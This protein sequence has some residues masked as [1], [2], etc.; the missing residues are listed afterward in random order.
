MVPFRPTHVRHPKFGIQ[1]L[2][3]DVAENWAF[4]T[5]SALQAEGRC[6]HSALLFGT[7]FEPLVVEAGR[8]LGSAEINSRRSPVRSTGRLPQRPLSS[9]SSCLL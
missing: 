4:A 3:V 7:V 5:A 2:Q 8:L 1:F 6:S 9:R